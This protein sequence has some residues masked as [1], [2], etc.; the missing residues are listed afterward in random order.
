MQAD[1]VILVPCPRCVAGAPAEW[2]P[3]GCLGWCDLC[4][5]GREVEVRVA[6]LWV[7]GIDQLKHSAVLGRN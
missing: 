5:G 2:L 7:Q 1:P 4:G 6:K 3:E